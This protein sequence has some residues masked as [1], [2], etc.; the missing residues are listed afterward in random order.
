MLVGYAA[1]ARLFLP[2]RTGIEL[3]DRLVRG[4]ARLG[5]RDA[6]PR[7][8]SHSGLS[9]RANGGVSYASRTFVLRGGSTGVGAISFGEKPGMDCLR[10]HARS[11]RSRLVSD[12]ASDRA[13]RETVDGWTADSLMPHNHT[14]QWTGP[15]SCVLVN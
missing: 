5:I 8:S 14:L 7:R 12:R 10:L 13:V 4:R 11:R 1:A 6:K 15:A 9:R 3:A 2:G